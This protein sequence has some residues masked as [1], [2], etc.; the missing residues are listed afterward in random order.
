MVWP[1]LTLS[2]DHP[3]SIV[4]RATRLTHCRVCPYKC[5][6]SSACM[7]FCGVLVSYGFPNIYTSHTHTYTPLN[8]NVLGIQFVE[9]S[10]THLSDGLDSYLA[11]CQVAEKY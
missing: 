11:V 4:A 7:H 6:F 2:L 5:N 9:Y 3:N 1:H 10:S 8:L